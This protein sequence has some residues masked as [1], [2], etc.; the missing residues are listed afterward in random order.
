M[1]IKD[2]KWEMTPDE[3]GMKPK[4]RVVCFD[5]IVNFFF[6]C[7]FEDGVSIDSAIKMT[8]SS[9]WSGLFDMHL[10]ETFCSPLPTIGERAFHN[11]MHYKCCGENGCDAVKVFGVPVDK[12]YYEELMKRRGGEARIQ[13]WLEWNKTEELK[14]QLRSLGYL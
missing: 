1:R 5:C 10:R 6:D 13:P 8:A 12:E 7:L 2:A 14:R 9:Y 11:D 4:F 3:I